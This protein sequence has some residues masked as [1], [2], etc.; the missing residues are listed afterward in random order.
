MD[1][2]RVKSGS[3]V[4]LEDWDPGETKLFPGDKNAAAVVL[5]HLTGELEDLQELLIAEHRHK[6]LIVLQAMDTGGKDGVIKHVFEGVNP[7][8]V[9]VA[10]FKVP[11]QEELDH[12]FL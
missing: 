7:A 10:S 6:I 12:D 8:G 3:K 5:E 4:K 9:S 1:S 11:T 2:Y